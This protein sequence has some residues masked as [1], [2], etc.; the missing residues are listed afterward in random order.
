ME[1][2][3]GVVERERERER[4]E[5]GEN[6]ILESNCA[7]KGERRVNPRGKRIFH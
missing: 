2:D 1:S 7:V 3:A 4:D 5:R 6:L